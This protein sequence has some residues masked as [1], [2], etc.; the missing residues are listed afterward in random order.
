M[1]DPND[2]TFTT[3]NV[4]IKYSYRYSREEVTDFLADA[5][6]KHTG[7]LPL[8]KRSMGSL[9]REWATH[10]AAWFLGYRRDHSAS[11]DLNY[12]QR[13]WVKVLYL[14]CGSFALLWE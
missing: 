6:Q 9:L 4:H 7:C 11:V 10:K 12:P 5:K 2:V 14:I 8:Q 13:W 3:G 1:I